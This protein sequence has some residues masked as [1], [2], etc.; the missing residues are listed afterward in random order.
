MKKL[1]IKKILASSF[2][3][4]FFVQA[5]FFLVEPTIVGAS[6]SATSTPATVFSLIVDPG[7]SISYPADVVM[8]A[9]TVAVDSS[10]TDG[11]TF[12]TVKT[13]NTAGYN[14]KVHADAAPALKQGIV[15]NFADFSLTKAV[16]IPNSTLT[17]GTKAFGFSGYGTD[18][19]TNGTWGTG[20]SCGTATVP[21]STLLFSG[22]NGTTDIVLA[23]KATI[24]PYAGIDTH[25][26]FSAEQRDIYATNGAYTTTITATATTI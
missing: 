24:T 10:V 1:F 9:L 18:V 14:L 19:T 8:P 26:C 4:L 17:T 23:S 6:V 21:L 13:N 20:S 25:I 11:T 15:D 22:F 2:I 5:L 16:W 3:S 12:W 7:I